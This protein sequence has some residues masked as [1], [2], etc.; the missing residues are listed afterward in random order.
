MG[1]KKAVLTVAEAKQQLKD[2]VASIQPQKFLVKNFWPVTF[3]CFVVGMLSADSV[4]I[5]EN[6]VSLAVSAIKKV[7]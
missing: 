4:K 2:S 7:I 3:G 5:R 6:I 1:K